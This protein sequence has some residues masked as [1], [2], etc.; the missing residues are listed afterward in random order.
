[1]YSY[2]ENNLKNPLITGKLAKI[3]ELIELIILLLLIIFY[4]Y[5][6]KNVLIIFYSIPLFA[7]FL[8]IIYNY[9]QTPRSF[10]DYF[11][12][13]FLGVILIYSLINNEHISTIISTIGASVHL[14][15]IITNRNIISIV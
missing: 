4:S 6:R 12:L 15:Q 14:F 3:V 11:T 5:Q 7:H 9:R 1:M 13:F 8:Q 2:K 10:I